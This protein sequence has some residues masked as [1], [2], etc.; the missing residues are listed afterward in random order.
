MTN[1]DKYKL[2]FSKMHISDDF[3]LEVNKMAITNKKVRLNKLIASVAVCALIISGATVGYAADIGGIQRTIQLWIHGE[4]TNVTV[5][6][7]GNGNYTIDYMGDD[8]NIKQQGGGGVAFDD[9]GNERPL[10]EEELIEQLNSPEVNYNEDGTVWV[11][12][13]NEK[14]EISDKFQDGVCYIKL[15][16][17]DNSLYMTVKYK[18]GWS[19]SPH[20]FLA[21]DSWSASQN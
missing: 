1:R 15:K 8:G 2:A 16:N 18:G 17:R 6:F 11:Y 12:W 7:D 10:T 9:E 14:I 3:A 5:E 19:T 13:I 20:K 4:Q 21:P